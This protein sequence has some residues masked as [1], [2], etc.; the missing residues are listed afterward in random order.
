VNRECQLKRREGEE[1]SLGKGGRRGSKEGKEEE[2][3]EG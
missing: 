1:R 3:R 2:E